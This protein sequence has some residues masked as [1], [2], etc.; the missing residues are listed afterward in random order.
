MIQTPGLG[1]LVCRLSVLQDRASDAATAAFGDPPKVPATASAAVHRIEG[2]VLLEC[3]DHVITDRTTLSMELPQ[4]YLLEAGSGDSAFPLCCY[5]TDREVTQVAKDIEELLR[6]PV[7]PC[8]MLETAASSHVLSG[9]AG[10]SGMIGPSGR[11]SGVPVGGANTGSVFS[12]MSRDGGV[13]FTGVGGDGGS[14]FRSSGTWREWGERAGRYILDMLAWLM[15]R[16]VFVAFL[17]V[18]LKPWSA[19]EEDESEHQYHWYIDV[20]RWRI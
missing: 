2:A 3:C 11:G 9:R 19:V 15:L 20:F 7:A 6:M 10:G 17:L 14:V 13:V 1:I 5:C 18:L 4:R 8:C 16:L 12:N